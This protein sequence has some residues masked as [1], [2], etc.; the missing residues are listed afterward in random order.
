[1][2]TLLLV[3]SLVGGLFASNEDVQEY[4]Q[5]GYNQ[6]RDKMHERVDHEPITAEESELRDLL[7]DLMLEVDFRN[8]EGE[9]KILAMESIIEE[10]TV[11]ADELGVDITPFIERFEERV[12]RWEEY[13]SEEWVAFRTY[14]DELKVEFD[15]E[16]LTQEE[17]VAAL[18]ELHELMVIKADELGIDITEILERQQDRADHYLFMNSE[19]M[20]EFKEYAQELR[21]SYDFDNMTT[22]EKVAALAEIKELVEAKA[23]ELGID[24]DE[25]PKPKIGSKQRGRMHDFRS[26]FRAGR[27]HERNQSAEVPAGEEA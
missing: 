12:A 6:M 5:N 11:K 15:L 3:F 1:M 18:D 21:D 4:A 17:K 19:E 16:N 9:E 14:M 10:L 2:K 25:L 23:E 13:N 26:G 22:E 7:H 20:T 27:R 24:L 8:L